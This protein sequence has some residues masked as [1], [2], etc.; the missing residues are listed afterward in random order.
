MRRTMDFH[1]TS[2]ACAQVIVF[3]GRAKVFSRV[4]LS[5]PFKIKLHVFSVY[6]FYK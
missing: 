5:L 2:F 4:Y 6:S 1:F 3:N